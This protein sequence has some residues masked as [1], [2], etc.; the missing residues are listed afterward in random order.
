MEKIVLAELVEVQ[1]R[2][3]GKLAKPATTDD[4]TA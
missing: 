2:L 1:R 3:K 4:D